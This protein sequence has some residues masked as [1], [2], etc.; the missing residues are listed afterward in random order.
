M[1][2]LKSPRMSS[3][4]EAA[5]VI[6]H[7]SGLARQE[8]LRRGETVDDEKIF[9]VLLNVFDDGASLEQL[10]SKYYRYQLKLS[11]D[12]LSCSLK[13]GEREDQGETGGVC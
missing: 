11:R 3:T 13:R 12:I 6:E 1:A 7:L 10:K 5:F 4:E 2:I 8:V 9:K